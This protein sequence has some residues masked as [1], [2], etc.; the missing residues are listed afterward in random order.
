MVAFLRLYLAGCAFWLTLFDLL[1]HLLNWR[2]L[3]WSGPGLYGLTLLLWL[4]SQR[5]L[6]REG[7]L[8][9]IGVLLLT[10][11][12]S[13]V[14]QLIL[15]SVRNWHYNPRQRLHPAT[16]G[17]RT[18]TR[19][20]IPA[21]HGPVP[22]L[23]VVPAGGAVAAVSL[24]HGSGSD[25]VFYTWEIVDALIAEGIAVLL[26]DMDGHGESERPQR[27]PH[28]IYT[29]ADAVGWLRERHSRVGAIG[30]SLGGC[31]S[32]RATAEGM[33]V[34]ALVIIG[35]PPQLHLE[36]WHVRR[37][38]IGLARYSAL[39][40]LQHGSPYHLVRAWTTTPPIRA[41]IST[42]DLIEA[43][44][45]PGSLCHIGERDDVQV[46]LLLVYGDSDALIPP[47]SRAQIQAALPSWGQFHLLKRTTHLSLSIDPR[48]NRLV[49]AW[50]ARHLV[51][52]HVE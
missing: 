16:Y 10:L 28:I 26:I 50:L 9:G 51:P 24:A 38:A 22:A 13:V 15:A 17:D 47:A 19:L 45:L 44:D 43:L 2:G 12:P 7:A 14:A 33:S 39:R 46:P 8:R 37:E 42:W 41:A 48:M 30:V 29:V 23:Y 36:P 49:S 52:Q 3:R 6:W 4:R 31:V 35:S 18:I 20:D 1:A 27:F 40:Q 21:R 32:A 34:D 11:I 25:K 5:D